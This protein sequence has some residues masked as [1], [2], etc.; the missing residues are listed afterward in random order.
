MEDDE[1]D[2]E[3]EEELEEQEEEKAD[4]SEMEGEDEPEE[5]YTAWGGKKVKVEYS[6]T[7]L[8]ALRGNMHIEYPE[9]TQ[10]VRIFT[11]STF[12]GFSISVQYRTFSNDTNCTLFSVTYC[13]SATNLGKK[14]PHVSVAD[15][16]SQ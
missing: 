6:G 15:L 13:T 16:Q 7:N 14:T 4:E 11:S 1:K 3:R 5:E 2:Q 8:K 10:I 9:K 12:T